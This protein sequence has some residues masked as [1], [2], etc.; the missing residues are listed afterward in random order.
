MSKRPAKSLSADASGSSAIADLRWKS[1]V[2]YFTF[3]RD[4]YQDSAEMSRQDFNEWADSGSLGG[5]YNEN[6]R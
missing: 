5:W 6:L 2:A 3:A 4:G 1:G